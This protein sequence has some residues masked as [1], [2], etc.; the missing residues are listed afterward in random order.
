MLEEVLDP[1]DSSLILSI[2]YKGNLV[3]FKYKVVP[4]FGEQAP[5]VG[6]PKPQHKIFGAQTQE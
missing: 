1:L 2:F 6:T 4:R 5:S 3:T